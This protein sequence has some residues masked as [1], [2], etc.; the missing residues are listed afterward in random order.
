VQKHHRQQPADLGFVRKQFS[1]RASQPDFFGR[2]LVAIAVALVEDQV[3][4]GEN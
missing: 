2:Q 4:D 1:E 3:D